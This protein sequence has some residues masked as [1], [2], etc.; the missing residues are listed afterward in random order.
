MLS[1]WL[2]QKFCRVVNSQGLPII[3][4]IRD[5]DQTAKKM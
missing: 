3:K 5:E 4:A 1:I 2:R